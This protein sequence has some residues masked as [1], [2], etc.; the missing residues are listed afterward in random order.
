VL[1]EALRDL[2]GDEE[3]RARALAH[4]LRAELPRDA[5]W[6][7][8]F[9]ALVPAPQ[10]HVLAGALPPAYAAILVD[11]VASRPGTADA[12]LEELRAPGGG[13]SPAFTIMCGAR[14]E[15]VRLMEPICALARHVE[16]E[17]RVAALE[18]LRCWPGPHARAA[19]EQARTDV[20]A[21]VRAVARRLVAACETAG[22][23]A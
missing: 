9:F 23:R 21:R 17:V 1:D 11:E 3:A 2:I 13:A 14:T 10:A 19:G 20:D 12:L 8:S 5:G 16:A 15:D 4:L 22:G 6:C 7:F 18:A